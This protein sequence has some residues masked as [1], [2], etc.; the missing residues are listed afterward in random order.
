MNFEW[1][2]LKDQLNFK[3]HGVHFAEAATALYDPNAIQIKDFDSDKKEERFVVIGY[4]VKSK[5]LVVVYTIREYVGR[6]ESYRIISARKA[7]KQ[8]QKQ[9]EE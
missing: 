2:D 6:T 3:K 1:D 8:E 4:S 7:N 5:I 9:Y